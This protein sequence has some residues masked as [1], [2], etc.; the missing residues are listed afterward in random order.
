MSVVDRVRGDP[1]FLWAIAVGAL[2][3]VL[4][5][6]SLA[7]PRT[8]Y[9]GFVWQ[10]FWG[11]VQAD[12]HSAACAVRAGGVTEYLAST[13]ACQ[14]ATGTV[15]YPGYTVVSEIGYAVVLLVAIV[16]VIFMLRRLDIG[17]DRRFFYALVPFSLFGGALRVVEDATDTGAASETLTYPL[18]TL[19]IS[20]II[21]VTVFVVTLVAV[22]AAVWLERD[23][24]VDD[25]ARPLFAAGVLAVLATLAYLFSLSEAAGVQFHPQVLAVTLVIATGTAVAV[26]GLV[27]RFV[28]SVTAGTGLIG[29]VVIWG[30]AVDG[31]ANMIGLDWLTRLGAGPNL[32]PK[33]PANKYIVEFTA[34]V[35]PES[36]QA[37]TGAAWGF[38]AVKLVVAALV[39][40]AFDEQLFEESPR[41]T[42]LI[43][44]AVLA[45]GLG[46]GTRD[47]LRATLGV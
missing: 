30:H 6:G 47:V 41:S 33:H 22:L 13:G 42:I 27:D 14:A 20:P 7:F 24:V 46:P 31:A 5:G 11:P 32:V 17:S 25:Y 12:A 8:I 9:T 34:S 19:V 43:L 40:W 15:A 29:L 10:Y 4:V 44:V 45:V 1:E 39:L 38:L 18:N 2:T 16:G 37:V 21:Y 36:I 35:L 3:V 26:Y 23:G 28:P